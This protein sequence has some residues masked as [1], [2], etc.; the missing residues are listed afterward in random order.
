MTKIV[1]VVKEEALEVN[2]SLSHRVSVV[3]IRRQLSEYVLERNSSRYRD[4]LED[5]CNTWT[6]DVENINQA[7]GTEMSEWENSTLTFFC[8]KSQAHLCIF[9]CVEKV[10]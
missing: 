8:V 7:I 1:N 6:R 2:V 5:I 3:P 4:L 9:E 10:H